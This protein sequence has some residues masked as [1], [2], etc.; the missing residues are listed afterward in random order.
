QDSLH[1]A[2]HLQSQFKQMTAFL[3]AMRGQAEERLRSNPQSTLTRRQGRS[4]GNTNRR[5]SAERGRQAPA[6]YAFSSSNP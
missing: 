3:E 4:G 2:T 6:K 5:K 1:S